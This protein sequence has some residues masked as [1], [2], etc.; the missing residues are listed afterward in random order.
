MST[1]TTQR[2]SRRQPPPAPAARSPL[3]PLTIAAVAVGVVIVIVLVVAN[4]MFDKGGDREIAQAAVSRPADL[5]DGR[6]VGAADAP[7]TIDMWEDF[8]CPACGLFSRKT[9]PRLLQD[10]VAKGTVRLVYRD[11]AFLG[12]ESID[13]A[14]AARAAERLLGA[15]G[16]W[17]FHDLLFHN[18][19]GENEGAFSRDV[20][21]RMAVS[22]GIDRDAFLAALDDPELV[23]AVK[24]ETQAGAKEGVTSTPTLDVNGHKVTGAP[25][26]QTLA[27]YLDGLLATSATGADQ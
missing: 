14:V 4:G 17:A 27:D 15:G 24:A 16:F 19:H 12:Q 1:A 20:L 2:R 13:A 10:Y 23:A 18:Q 25:P 3:V 9:E 8:Q 5:I 7:I 22:L 26:Y 21:A 11:M 6:S